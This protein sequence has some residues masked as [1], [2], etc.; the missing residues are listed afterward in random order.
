MVRESQNIGISSSRHHNH[1]FSKTNLQEVIAWVFVE[2]QETSSSANIAARAVERPNFKQILYGSD[3]KS[4]RANR[5]KA[6]P[7]ECEN[8][9]CIEKLQAEEGKTLALTS[10]TRSRKIRGFLVYLKMMNE[11]DRKRS[12]CVEYVH[13]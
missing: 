5:C 10:W 9:E 4:M 11:R 2:A 8:N 6:S 12:N 1:V 13:T 3:D 7:W